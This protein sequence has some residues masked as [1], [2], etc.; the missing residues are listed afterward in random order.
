MT[1]VKLHRP[2]LFDVMDPRA[3]RMPVERRFADVDWAPRADVREN[4]KEFQL[5]VEL[6]GL[7]KKDIELSLKDNVLTLKGEKKNAH[8]TDEDN[9]YISE[10]SFGKFERNF[11]FSTNVDDR[12]IKAT[13]KNG[14]LS[15]TIPK[16][17]EAQP[18]KVEIK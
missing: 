1:I 17:P 8:E 16:V 4:D 14:V 2:S 10:R 13:H 7:E 6:P 12:K 11:R 3:C 9:R 5:I 15:I 18:A